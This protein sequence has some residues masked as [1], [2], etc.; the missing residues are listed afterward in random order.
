MRRSPRR[1]SALAEAAKTHAMM[2]VDRVLAH[3]SVEITKNK[4]LGNGNRDDESVGS[5][6][7]ALAGESET[8]GGAVD[9]LV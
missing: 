2:E 9:R 8:V 1:G 7:G 3:P 6:R 4:R 5:L